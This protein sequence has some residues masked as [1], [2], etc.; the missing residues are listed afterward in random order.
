M[1]NL[2]GRGAKKN[3]SK[4]ILISGGTKGIGRAIAESLLAAGHQVALFSPFVGEIENFN[5]AAVGV[6]DPA[7]MLVLQGDVTSEESV[8]EVVQ[9]T[10]ACFGRIDVLI[11]NA[12]RYYASESDTVDIVTFKNVIDINL[13]GTAILTKA[14]VPLMK[15]QGGGQII[16]TA[17]TT[18]R[19]V[20]ARSE[21]YG[22]T[23]QAIMGYAQGIR[24]E[25]RDFKIKVA[26]VCPGI[27]N[28][29]AVG[30][31]ELAKRPAG[32]QAMLEPAEVA[33]VFQFIVEQPAGSDI[34]DILI[35]PFGSTRYHF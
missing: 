22:A 31:D 33:R 28:T 1:K 16:M 29:D 34:R 25:L 24:A 3:M 27:T 9:K 26:T 35:T 23:K 18:G 32:E 2:T 15:R 10:V 4:V 13:V 5:K 20:T 8:R 21:F 12:G 11:N 17:S 14:V 6:C 7:K 30:S 19:H